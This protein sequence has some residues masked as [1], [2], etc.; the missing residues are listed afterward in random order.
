[1]LQAQLLDWSSVPLSNWDTVD[2]GVG[3]ETEESQKEHLLLRVIDLYDRA[4]LWERAI[5]ACEQ[6]RVH[7]E[8]N[9]FDYDKLAGILERQAALFRKIISQTRYFPSYFRVVFYSNRFAPLDAC[10]ECELNRFCSGPTDK[11]SSTVE[12]NWSPLWI[13]HSGSGQC[14]RM[15]RSS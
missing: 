10:V 2:G 1:M 3:I 4:E 7:Y 9:L 14:T 13:S 6:L 12:S 15:R 5:Q 8:V 11:S